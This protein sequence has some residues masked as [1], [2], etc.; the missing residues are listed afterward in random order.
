MTKKADSI[1]IGYGKGGKT[2]AGYLAGK[3]EQ[4]A[5][6]EQSDKMYGGTCINVGCI[7][8]K[9]LV[10]SAER[11]AIRK[12]EHFEE[13]AAVYA[14]A[15]E[16]KTA[17]VE[18]LRSKNYHML[19]DKE[20]VTVY[21]GTAGFIDAHTV[22]VVGPEGTEQLTA[23]KIFIN[24]GSVPVV[25]P[26]EGLAESSRV[27][28]SETIMDLKEL[29]RKLAIIGGGYIGLEYASF[30]RM[31]GSEVT[32][33]QNNT[34]FIPR[35]DRDIAAAVQAEMTRQGIRLEFGTEIWRVREEDGQAVIEYEQAGTPQLLSADAVLVATGRRP[36]TDD[37]HLEKAGIATLPRGG[38][39]TDRQRQTTQPH[40]WAM[41]DVVGGLQFTY[42]SLDDFRIVRAALEGGTYQDWGRY[43]P[44]SVF[45]EPSLSRVGLTEK[46]ARE[47]GLKIAVA[48]LPVAAIPKAHVLKRPQGLLK[49]IVDRDSQ[50]ILGATLFCPESYEMINI[51]KLAMDAGLTYRSLRDQIF[52]HPTMSE[53]LND[54]FGQIKV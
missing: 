44:Y 43:I 1:I 37:L 26:I 52:T 18:K 32:V 7:P 19:A 45:I 51:V 30:Y 46:E 2:L 35:E 24:T 8:T 41:G 29:P 9:S 39:R 49:A 12:L 16:D 47:K 4:V 34:E 15:I 38:I 20:N 27:Y 48:T 23:P 5:I 28:L 25:P 17:L 33:L 36:N 31:F 22:E 42:V 11:A 14:Q 10:D 54:L 6:V 21:L 3:G 40:I 13:K 53:S 50:K